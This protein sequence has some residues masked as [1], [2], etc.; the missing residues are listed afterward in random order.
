MPT[1]FEYVMKIFVLEYDVSKVGL[2]YMDYF[3]ISHQWF[4]IGKDYFSILPGR[5]TMWYRDTDSHRWADIIQRG[6][7][8]VISAVM[9]TLNG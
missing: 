8:T 3:K 7:H 9:L 2:N 6:E 5:L 1:K 4:I